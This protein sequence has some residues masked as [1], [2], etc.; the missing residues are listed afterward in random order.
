MNR[1]LMSALLFLTASFALA[2]QQSPRPEQ[3]PPDTSAQQQQPPQQPH[4]DLSE[5]NSRIQRSVE[6]LLRGDTVLSGADIQVAVDDY[7][8]TLTGHVDSYAQHQRVMAL[9]EQYTRYRKVV[10]KLQTR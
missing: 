4:Q 6:D 2:V 7:S 9:L 3:S 1:I 8:I 10:D 5:A